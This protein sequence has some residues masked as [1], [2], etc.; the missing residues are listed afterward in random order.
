M[1]LLE[2]IAKAGASVA[3]HTGGD[4]PDQ[5]NPYRVGKIA[6]RFPEMKILM[7]HIGCGGASYDL[8]R[9]AIEVAKECS[10]IT[11]V[12]SDIRTN[13]LLNAMKELG[14]ERIC[15]GSD[16]P[17]ENMA[18]EVARYKTM[19]REKLTEDE[20]D[21]VMGRNLMKFLGCQN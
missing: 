19:F 17:F 5:T 2:E 16:T 11:L 21:C 12:G 3:F 8:S 4:A 1:P 20:M 9:A 15:F 6:K 13:S 7:V 10:N 18:V 14:P